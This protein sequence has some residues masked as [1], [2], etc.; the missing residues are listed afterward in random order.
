M[1]NTE[2]HRGV[3]KWFVDAKGYGFITDDSGGKDV[4]VHFS[5]IENNEKKHRYLNEGDKVEFY[6][7]ESKRTGKPEAVMVRVMERVKK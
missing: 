1:A 6:I 5:S 4:F 2:K 7:E 3:V